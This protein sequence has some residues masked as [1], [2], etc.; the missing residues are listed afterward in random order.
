MAHGDIFT[1][2][3]QYLQIFPL[4]VI[5]FRFCVAWY[6]EVHGG[7]CV[8]DPLALGVE[9]GHIDEFLGVSRV[10]KVDSGGCFP[11]AHDGVTDVDHAPRSLFRALPACL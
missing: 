9:R 8:P 1:G 5:G 11:G 4:L 10:H 6:P 7:A 3:H 2:A